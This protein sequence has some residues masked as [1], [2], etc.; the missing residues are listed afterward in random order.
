MRGK[1]LQ[2]PVPEAIVEP[3]GRIR[4]SIRYEHPSVSS[5]F[6]VVAS[7]KVRFSS[8]AGIAMSFGSP[9]AWFPS[10]SVS[11]RRA[12]AS[13][14]KSTLWE[15]DGAPRPLPTHCRRN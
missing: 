4:R 15:E 2:G 1:S 9:P 13:T 14:S 11:D 5:Q 12:S 10:N 3:T 6:A 8:N 7:S